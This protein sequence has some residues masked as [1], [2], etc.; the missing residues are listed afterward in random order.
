MAT[1]VSEFDQAQSVFDT[2][3]ASYTNG[4]VVVDGAAA[5]E[6]TGYN[7]SQRVEVM[8]TGAHYAQ[9]QMGTV[10][11]GGRVGPAIFMPTIG[12]TNLTTGA[13]Y[14]FTLV[15]SANNLGNTVALERKAAQSAALT[16]LATET[17]TGDARISGSKLEVFGWVDGTAVELRGYV[18]GVEVISFRDTSGAVPL[19]QRKVGMWASGPNATALR[20]ERFQA[21]DRAIPTGPSAA[22]AVPVGLVANT[23]QPLMV[24][25]QWNPVPTATSYEVYRQIGGI[26][27]SNDLFPSDTLFPAAPLDPEAW[28]LIDTTPI[29]NYTDTDL[30]EDVVYNYAIKAVNAA[31][32]S[33][34]SEPAGAVPYFGAGSKWHVW[35]NGTLVP[36][37]IRGVVDQGQVRPIIRH[38]IYRREEEPAPVVNPTVLFEMTRAAQTV[39][40]NAA[41][42]QAGTGAITETRINWGDGSA[43][44][45]L[46]E[47]TRTANHTYSPP[48]GDEQTYTVAVEV[49]AADGGVGTRA[50]E[51]TVPGVPIID[52]GVT[53]PTLSFTLARTDQTVT[54]NASATTAGSSAIARHEITWGD[55]SGVQ[56]ITEPTRTAN[57]VY[58]PPAAGQTYTVAVKAVATDGGVATS[59]K[60]IS[61]PAAGGGGVGGNPTGSVTRM[62]AGNLS[63][64]G[65]TVGATTAGGA[66]VK[67]VA[68]T[69]PTLASPVVGS[70]VTPDG[71][72]Y[73]KPTITGLQPNTTYYYGLQ[74]GSGVDMTKV[75]RLKTAPSSG[76]FSFCFTSCA[77]GTA[78]AGH[79]VAVWTRMKNAG[80]LF[81][82][83]T[84]DMTYHNNSTAS[85]AAYHQMYN[86]W[87]DGTTSGPMLRET[88]AF[89]T[90]SDHDFGPNNSYGMGGA[91]L[92]AKP[93]AQSAY[94]KRMPSPPLPSATGGI[95]HTF[96]IGR[97]R[98]V[99]LDCRSYKTVVQSGTN[100]AAG[101]TLIGSEQKAWV[102]STITGSA[103]KYIIV[104]SDVPFSDAPGADDE[105]A[106][107]G[108][109]RTEMANF[110]KSS[111]KFIEII[112]GDQHSIGYDDGTNSLGI[113]VMHGAS[114]NSGS[115]VKTVPLTFGPV[116]GSNQYG[117][118]EI[119]DTGGTTITRK[120]TAFDSTGAARY[121]NSK[122][123]T[124]GTGGG[125]GTGGD[126][127]APTAPTNLSAGTATATSIPLTWTASTD[128]VGVS[129]YNVYNNGILL[130]QGLTGTSG[131]V[132]GLTAS[133]QYVLTLR[134]YDAA[135]NLSPAS[136]SVTVTTAASGGGGGGGE[137]GRP[138]IAYTT[139]SFFRKP[140]PAVT[141]VSSRSAAGVAYVKGA[142]PSPFLKIRG[143]GAN[144]WGMPYGMGTASDPVW[145]IGTGSVIAAHQQ[146]LKVDGFRAP[147]TYANKLTG[148]SDS[149]GIIIDVVNGKTIHLYQ[150]SKGT[151][152]IINVTSA[153]V[154]DHNSN[155]LDRRNPL[156]NSNYNERSRGVIPDS[157]MIRVDL[158]DWA[159]K[160]NTGLGHV[161]EC[162]W[163]GTNTSH[164]FCHPMIAEES[165]KTGWGAEGERFRIK[166][167][168]NLAARPAAQSN[169][170]GLAIARTLQQ[171]GA[172]LGDNSGSGSGIKTEQ[173]ATY[174]GLNENSLQ[175]IMTWDDIE[176]L[177]LGWDG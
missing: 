139:T 167:G 100:T 73:S 153:G 35:L 86:Y 29:A 154:F 15:N 62:V 123:Y 58:T 34:L 158:L 42:T 91:G 124:V 129:G 24:F 12:T 119:T 171:H 122:T 96:V 144:Q 106:A 69:S 2:Y 176:F 71:A 65:F 60:T 147:A 79:N 53:N 57:H 64:T 169:P 90:W 126:T 31:G 56:T 156:S 84:G 127:Q 43:V 21:G 115:S 47:P 112:A 148:T 136:N 120:F 128:A 54:M 152:N 95:Y 44:T 68:S 9:M 49:R 145:K 114:I 27:P 30:T 37:F 102:K 101:K 165:N 170:A 111:G 173:G 141:P 107:Y 18:N 161:L 132:T 19:T 113:P 41:G 116:G 59:S 103:E 66:A 160:N 108:L 110:F 23:P 20:V 33:A 125:G 137:T 121:T 175:G 16:T 28:E 82:F 98:F 94:R 159:V 150:A 130:W 135:G 81:Y 25:L 109:E 70:A 52:P 131:T 45:V 72:G 8:A 155:G 36:A 105:W 74:L 22:P 75:Y 55:G 63:S 142:D 163:V 40:V 140:L 93:F 138:F 50:S 97:V 67:L 17:I 77:G 85:E 162:F 61:V 166:P 92:T 46:T 78:G 7:V 118:I 134:A 89:Y 80:Y 3:W 133:T 168:I 146:Y 38:Y 157:M 117:A 14:L 10:F 164:G 174:P 151:G 32:T 48:A 172:Y 104:V 143:T 4:F 6:T 83:M 149:P 87:M 51:I 13:F 11:G 88:P 5:P 99:V 26:V 76:S 1:F 177:P 39:T